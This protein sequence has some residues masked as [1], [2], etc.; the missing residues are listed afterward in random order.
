MH[1]S[2][3]PAVNVPT[4]ILANIFTIVCFAPPQPQSSANEPFEQ[5]FKRLAHSAASTRTSIALTCC[6]WREVTESTKALWR[7]LYVYDYK[8]M[9][10]YSP[11]NHFMDEIVDTRMSVQLDSSYLQQDALDALA[12]RLLK[13]GYLDYDVNLSYDNP[14]NNGP[15]FQD[16]PTPFPYLRRLAFFGHGH[17]DPQALNLTLA[18]RLEILNCYMDGDIQLQLAPLCQLRDLTLDGDVN[19]NN[20]VEIL[21][22]CPVLEILRLLNFNPPNS[23]S[24]TLVCPSL[25]YLSLYDRA[26]EFCTIFPL[27]LLHSPKLEFLSVAFYGQDFNSSL[28]QPSLRYLSVDLISWHQRE[29]QHLQSLLRSCNF[30]RRLALISAVYEPSSRA[31]FF[32]LLQ[33]SEVLPNLEYLETDLY[34]EKRTGSRNYLG[35]HP[36][37]LD[38]RPHLTL[39]LPDK[40]ESRNYIETFPA[41]ASRIELCDEAVFPTITRYIPLWHDTEEGWC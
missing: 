39:V 11:S 20:L 40:P 12:L 35:E 33:S 6:R 7:M 27:R 16:H 31:W 5:P 26:G 37:V 23:F 2:L 10:C 1:N 38:A 19:P 34:L 24:Q 25:R 9:I 41:Y 36:A 18:P 29:L 14:N 17:I 15:L 30:L 22:S 13:V 21:Q 32:E 28:E 3:R 8:G 4:E